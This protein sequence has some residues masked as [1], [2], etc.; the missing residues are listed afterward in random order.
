MCLQGASCPSSPGDN[1]IDAPHLRSPHHH[2][3]QHPLAA[4]PP[5]MAASNP[6]A[7]LPLP[8]GGRARVGG[9]PRL[10]KLSSFSW[11]ISLLLT[12]GA[13]CL[14]EASHAGRQP[15]HQLELWLGVNHRRR[16][17]P[18]TECTLN[19]QCR[20][21]VCDVDVNRGELL[22]RRLFTVGS[23][24]WGPELRTPPAPVS[25]RCLPRPAPVA[26]AALLHPG[27]LRW[28]SACA[29]RRGPPPP[30]PGNLSCANDG[31]HLQDGMY[32]GQR[33]PAPGSTAVPMP[34]Y[35]SSP[36]GSAM[37]TKPRQVRHPAASRESGN[38]CSARCTDSAAPCG[39]TGCDQITGACTFP[40]ASV[41]C[42]AASCTGAI[43]INEDVLR[44]SSGNCPSSTTDCSPYACGAGAPASSSCTSTAECASGYF[45]DATSAVC[46]SGLASDGPL[47]IDT[48]AGS[49][50]AAC[51][52][53]TG[54]AWALPEP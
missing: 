53:V 31:H 9:P 13:G 37:K 36:P 45:C 6:I 1:G 35:R 10:M 39:A 17:R 23:D 51:C 30:C 29:C 28:G 2:G 50:M 3:R 42:A 27:H 11:G 19:A 34:A 15:D 24:L 26:A 41:S 43:Q 4:W 33:L 54:I 46:C 20:S 49:D 32:R 12:T 48:V 14:Q 16:S 22:W 38:C 8:R 7:P 18:G 40:D 21:G 44:R 5:P 47:T 25:T 52:G